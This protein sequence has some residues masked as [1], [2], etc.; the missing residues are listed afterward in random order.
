MNVSVRS[1]AG[2]ADQTLIVGCVV[3]GSG[4]KS[5]LV[6]GIGPTL[7]NFQ[8]PNA[9]VDPQLRIFAGGAMRT[10]NDNWGQAPNVGELMQASTRLGAFPLPTGSRD[11]AVL[12]TFSAGAWSMQVSGPAAGGVALIE[13]YDADANPLTS[14]ARLINLSAR[15]QVGREDQALFA[16]FVVTGGPRRVLIRGVG[17]SLRAFG[18]DGTLGNPILRLFSGSTRIAEN[19][20][21]VSSPDRAAIEA[22]ARSVN[23]FALS[24]PSDAALVYTLS[25][26]VYSAQVSGADGGTGVGLVEVYELP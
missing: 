18:V 8:V 23:A 5:L 11:S 15:T 17:P 16:G 24:H 4:N 12:D 25:P 21:Y 9:L 6:R 2:A 7:G 20:D 26:G 1:L 3:A 19:D 22:A 13:V 10:S 14:P